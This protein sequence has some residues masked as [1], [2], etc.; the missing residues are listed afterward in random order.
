MAGSDKAPKRCAPVCHQVQIGG[1][2][3]KGERNVTANDLS[4][5]V[6]N[7]PIGVWTVACD[8]QV[9]ADLRNEV[10]S[11]DLAVAPPALRSSGK[12]DGAA[13]GLLPTGF[14]VRK[15][16]ALLGRRRIGPR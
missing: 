10:A 12:A 9:V 1:A 16:D 2:I 7:H 8:V 11:A 14:R 5:S 4:R 3:A 13:A 6:A 15:D